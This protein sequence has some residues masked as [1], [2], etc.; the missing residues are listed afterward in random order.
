MAV[1][2]VTGRIV[3]LK[4]LN[5]SGRGGDPNMFVISAHRS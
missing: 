3:R 2:G 1:S 4:S 5:Q